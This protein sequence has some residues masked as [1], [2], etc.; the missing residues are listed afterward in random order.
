[1]LTAVNI[2]A[3]SRAPQSIFKEPEEG[4]RWVFGLDGQPDQ[5][6]AAGG[7]AWAS[8]AE[9]LGELPVTAEAS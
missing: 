9:L 4:V 8:V 6:K 1:M 5:V 2:M 3:R 7:D